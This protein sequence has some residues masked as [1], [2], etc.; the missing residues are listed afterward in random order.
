M[1]ETIGSRIARMREQSGLSQA[2]LAKRM[3][4]S[5]AG[6]QS[7]ECGANS[8]STDNLISLAKI[9]HVS[10]D[11][12]LDIDATNTVNLDGYNAH[13]QSL[14]FHLLQY[15]N[16]SASAAYSEKE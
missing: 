16:E 10:T 14:V 7:W 13:E 5:R 4:I 3:N 1:I 12:L 8:P 9:F 6:V 15:F 11:Y 2:D